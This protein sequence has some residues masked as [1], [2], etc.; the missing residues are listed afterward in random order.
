M[1]RAILVGMIAS[2]VL[3]GAFAVLIWQVQSSR[4]RSEL[5]EELIAV[6]LLLNH[7]D[8]LDQQV[9]YWNQ[10]GYSD[11]DALRQERSTLLKQAEARNDDLDL[12]WGVGH[13]GLS[14][15]DPDKSHAVKQ[16][17]VDTKRIVDARLEKN[18]SAMNAAW[19]ESRM[20]DD[21]DAKPAHVRKWIKRTRDECRAEIEGLETKYGLRR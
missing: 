20:K 4:K 11:T 2:V 5:A 16:V 12:R 7:A 19:L 1:R 13:P 9:K 17:E 18:S 6:L 10:F 8:A 21:P 3:G 15:T 14:K